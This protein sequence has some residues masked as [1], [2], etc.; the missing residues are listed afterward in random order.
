MATRERLDRLEISTAEGRGYAGGVKAL[1]ASPA[2][3]P[4][5]ADAARCRCASAPTRTAP[6]AKGL[7][8]RPLLGEPRRFLTCVGT[9]NC[10]VSR[11]SP[12]PPRGERAGER[13]PFNAA[14]A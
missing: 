9:V 2:A 14:P 11:S 1:F 6:Q 3:R 10:E 5:R 13:R 7:I 8:L 4:G 12:S